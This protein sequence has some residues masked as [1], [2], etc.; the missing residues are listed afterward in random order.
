MNR[1]ALIGSRDFAKQIRTHAEKTGEY[2]VV[3]FFDDFAAEGSLVD[4]LPILGGLDSVD[5]LFAKSMFDC[6]FFAAGYNNFTFR[7]N[8]FTRFKG[9]IPFANIIMPSCSIGDNVTLGEGIF[10]GDYNE[11]GD[12]TTIEDNVFVH[13]RTIIGHDNHIGAHSYISG[14]FDSAGFVSMGKR[15]FYGIRTCI[16]DHVFICDDV[17]IGLGCIV[18]K[19]IKEP[20]KYMSACVKLYKIE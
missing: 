20:G 9:R 18:G 6:L 1:L 7:D 10:L 3:G 8:A 17:W 4:G 13:G 19:D 14:R 11:V 16:S 5:V 2:R 15:N 12:N